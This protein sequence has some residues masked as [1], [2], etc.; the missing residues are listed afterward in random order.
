[1]LPLLELVRLV[2]VP[3]GADMGYLSALGIKTSSSPK[4]RKAQALYDALKSGSINY[5]SFRE[6]RI[7]E[8]SEVIVFDVEIQ[9]GQLKVN[10][11]RKVERV[12]V[13]FFDGDAV[14]PKVL[15]LREDFPNVPHVNLTAEEFPR[16]LCLYDTSYDEVKLHWTSASFIGRIRWWLAET[17]KGKLHGDDQP[18]EPLLFAAP[19]TIVLP[20]KYAKIGG[21]SASELIYVSAIST[22][23]ND[24]FFIVSDS[25]T[26]NS[27]GRVKA[28]G[29]ILNYPP[30]VHGIIRHKPPHLAALAEMLD[31]PSLE[32]LS[33]LRS[34]LEVFL[35]PEENSPESLLNAKFILISSFPKKRQAGSSIEAT[36]IYAFI[37]GSTVEEVGVA[38]GLWER[39]ENGLGRLLPPPDGMDGSDILI[40]TLNTVFEFNQGLAAIANG[41]IDRPKTNIAAIGA[42]ALGS[43]LIMNAARAGI[44]ESWCII[45]DDRLYPHN[46]ARH[47][48]DGT[49][50]GWKKAEALQVVANSLTPSASPFSYLSANVLRPGDS[51]Q[52]VTTKALQNC[53]TI[54]DL[55]ASM[56]VSR[57]LAHD[58]ASPARRASLFLNHAGND[59]VLL[60]EGEGRRI[61]LN[62]LE[63]Q[64][65][66]ACA[67]DNRLEGHLSPAAVSQRYGQTCQ[68]V[69]SNFAQS[70]IAMHAAIGAAELPRILSPGKEY[71]SIWRLGS[72]STTS[73]VD[74]AV[75]PVIFS[76]VGNWT[77]CVGEDIYGRLLALRSSHLPNETGGVLIG[78]IDFEKQIVYVVDTLPSPPDSEEW[79]SLYIR[80][81]R[82]LA[83]KEHAIKVKSDGM[84]HYVGEWHSHPDGCSTSPSSDDIKVF[85]WLEKRMDVHGLP[86]T[87]FIVGEENTINPFVGTIQAE[88][89]PIPHPDHM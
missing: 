55:S 49:F 77:L 86:A 14:L 81:R 4:L 82:G 8:R 18:L 22:D 53:N 79:P 40:E 28:F 3:K 30:Q 42:G 13:E 71:I 63:M 48:L 5:V 24:S 72:D 15:V 26:A 61:P 33:E 45:D 76:S 65:Y 39:V 57:F 70:S 58:L 7:S 50:I 84:L 83:E 16:N 37:S 46:L 75:H 36:D 67:V 1:M 69:S 12:S 38:I 74:I 78:S 11:I 59:L 31:N 21:V 35:D 89:S 17:A 56:G 43:Q 52:E 25:A 73:R 23:L 85:A 2:L 51:L 29:V 62:V 68:D 34:Q 32:L 20:A 10:D 44:G 88:V 66:R 64:Y 19:G 47:A 80:G 41:I 27:D 6:F 87:M 54:L 9:V 60:S